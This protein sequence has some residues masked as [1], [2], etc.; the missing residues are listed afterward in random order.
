M[1]ARL[2][3]ITGLVSAGLL[4]ILLT[5]V[6]PGDA[7]AVGILA[8]F[9]LSYVSLLCM[10][11]FV[12]WGTVKLFDRLGHDLHVLKKTNSITLKKAYYYSTVIALGPIIIISLQSVGSV[13]IYDFGLIVTFIVLGC[14]YVARRTA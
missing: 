6:A 12:F 11:T 7:G 3:V 1:L 13:G 8:I 14:V 4:L 5:S 10:L 2:L 9:L